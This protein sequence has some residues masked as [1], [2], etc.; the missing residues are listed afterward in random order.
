M[1][2]TSDWQLPL[3][4]LQPHLSH[5]SR[6]IHWTR[7]ERHS[8]SH[9]HGFRCAEDG[10]AA[11]HGPQ[12]ATGHAQQRQLKGHVCSRY[13]QAKWKQSWLV[14]LASLSCLI[15]PCTR[16]RNI[17]LMNL[18]QAKNQTQGF[19]FISKPPTSTLATCQQGTTVGYS[20]FRFSFAL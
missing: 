17:L 15:P 14:S 2:R 16:F 18:I 9:A 12:H 6:P 10:P 4:S 20:A 1:P 5:H 11:G 13:L 19:G 8:V 3:A 7:D